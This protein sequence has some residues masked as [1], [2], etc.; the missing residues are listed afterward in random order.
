MREQVLPKVQ[1][2]A[3][4]QGEI[5]Y[6][7]PATFELERISPDGEVLRIQL[8]KPPIIASEEERDWWVRGLE[9]SA[10]LR[11][12][13]WKWTGPSLPAERPFFRRIL[14]GKLG[15]IWTWPGLPGER[16]IREGRE[17]WISKKT[18]AF[19]VFEHDGR[20]LGSVRLPEGARFRPFPGMYDPFI[21]GDTVWIF[22]QD[23]LDVKYLSKM[24]VRW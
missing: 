9:E 2:A 5:V 7:C 22:R 21:V 11:N 10:S 15:R 4:R 18:G 17:V 24:V 19:D 13:G 8:D 12:P 14:V 3:T 16:E 1:W 20:F 23:S 6:G